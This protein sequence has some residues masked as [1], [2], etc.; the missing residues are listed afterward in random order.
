MFGFRPHLSTQDILLQ[1]KNDIFESASRTTPKAIL[2]L[3][4]KGA[5]DNVAHA[6]ILK[7]LNNLGIG[8]RMYG[9]IQDFLTGRQA[10]I[11]VGHLQSATIACGSRGTP[12]GAVL[13]PMLFNIALINLPTELADIPD[14]HHA[15]YADD[16]TLWIHKGSAGTMQER[17]QQ[18]ANVVQAYAKRCGLACSPQKSELLLVQK[19]RRDPAT[20]IQIALDGYSIL[21]TST[22]KILGMTLQENCRNTKLIQK[23]DATTAQIVRML[24]R[25]ANQKHGM[26]E[27]DMLRLVQAFVVSRITYVAPYA[28][29][30]VG[31]RKR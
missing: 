29:L 19:S 11:K 21:P 16:I 22:I 24:R 2:A 25:I 13:S 18:A 6:S 12:Q 23:L 28:T 10:V 4:L 8:E 20:D 5:F 17:L 7:N 14:I 1:L 30:Q 26:K 31:E 9:Y 27:Q 3:D 15:I